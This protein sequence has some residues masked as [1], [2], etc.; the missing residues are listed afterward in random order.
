MGCSTSRPL[1]DVETP[2]IFLIKKLSEN[3]YSSRSNLQIFEPTFNLLNTILES[4]RGEGKNS[5]DLCVSLGNFQKEWT[6][7]VQENPLNEQNFLDFVLPIQKAFKVL[8]HTIIFDDFMAQKKRIEQISGILEAKNLDEF[9]LNGPAEFWQ[10]NFRTNDSPTWEEFFEKFTATYQDFFGEK[11]LESILHL[12]NEKPISKEMKEKII[13]NMK[14]LMQYQLESNNDHT[15]TKQ[16]WNVFSFKR[17]A[18]FDLRSKFIKDA[19]NVPRKEIHN[20]I[21]LNYFYEDG[22]KIDTPVEYQISENG[23]LNGY[24]KELIVKDMKTKFVS[25]GRHREN[26]I[27]IEKDEISRNHFKISMKKN[28]KGNEFR[29]EFFIH[30]LSKNHVHFVVEESG[31]LLSKNMIIRLSENKIFFIKDISPAY[32]PNNYYHSVEP[33]YLESQRKPLSHISSTI[34]K[35]FIEIEFNPPPPNVNQKKE[36]NQ[37][38]VVETD[39]KDDTVIIGS[40]ENVT[41]KIQDKDEDEDEDCISEN[42]CNLKYDS[43]NKCWIIQDKTVKLKSGNKDFYKTLI[44]CDNYGQYEHYPGDIPMRGIKLFDKM[45]FYLE[46]NVI[47]VEEK[48]S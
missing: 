6:S 27:K 48:E 14:V 8:Y 17:M 23:I 37:K 13:E 30:N 9:F 40:G 46:T 38:Y 3:I 4:V 39:E 45:K 28:L 21:I 34:T 35:P 33:Q 31:Y 7:L 22:E 43:K 29:N 36:A 19:S 25:F 1:S 24:N 5:N 47:S 18:D 15:I 10:T 16:G 12:P 11:K 26:D 2:C 20:E 32:K 41:W 44:R 42:H